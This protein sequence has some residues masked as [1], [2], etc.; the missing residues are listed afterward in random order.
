VTTYG[1]ALAAARAS[2]AEA[3]VVNAALDARLLLADAAG[4]DMAALVARDRDALP[5]VAR[6]AF[7]NHMKR[8]LKGEPAAR[9]I[10][11][12]EFWGLPIRLGSA[13][14]VPR[15]ETETLVEIV[16]AEVRQQFPPE[17][18]ICDLGTGTGAILIALL[19]ELP[20]ARG[21]AVD[22]SAEALS[23]A[24]LN[25]ERLGVAERIGFRELDF[26]EGPD[27]PF[28]VVVA[29]PPYIR[30]DVVAGL[31]HEVR[32]FDPLI[33]LDGG[34]D[35]LD[36][37]RAILGRID[38]LLKVNGLLGLE[39]GSDQGQAVASLCRSAGLGEVHVHHDLAARERVVTAVRTIQTG[40]A[41]TAKKA[42]GNLGRSG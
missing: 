26:A 15:P 30:S 14:L 35:G 38:S 12:K 18:T 2:L 42:L 36:A 11:E 27:G 20:E 39:V 28:H 29:N 8:R 10:G 24:R 32:D 40:A 6:A 13:A 23:V 4:L 7:R 1:A 34:P 31:A 19:T 37:Y 33:A 25:A 5:A 3:G 16:L 22:I 41:E 9:I 21:M 17:I